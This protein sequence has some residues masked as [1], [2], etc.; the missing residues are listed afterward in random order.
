MI[1][2]ERKCP[3]ATNEKFEVDGFPTCIRVDSDLEYEDV[4]INQLVEAGGKARPLAARKAAM[5]DHYEFVKC[6]DGLREGNVTGLAEEVWNYRG[7]VDAYSGG[8]RREVNNKA[9]EVDH[10]TEVQILNIAWCSALKKAPVAARTRAAKGRLQHI[11]ND[12]Q[13]LNVT[14]H[15]INQAKKGPFMKFVKLAVTDGDHPFSSAGDAECLADLARQSRT[16]SVAKLFEDGIW[17]KIELS[18][19]DAA[20]KTYD[21]V[22]ES[23][24]LG[25]IGD[26][27]ADS[28]ATLIEKMNL[29]V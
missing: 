19:Q 3:S 26:I 8:T 9:P 6:D 18:L 5:D 10:V 2:D 23:A 11:V 21:I 13:N 28:L 20:D 29:G 16:R 25:A 24:E 12:V 1:V 22:G 4:R 17:E 27:F 15:A 14:T 7:G